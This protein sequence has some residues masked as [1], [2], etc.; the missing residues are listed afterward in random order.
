MS[1]CWYGGGVLVSEDLGGGGVFRTGIITS[2]VGVV[3]FE[4]GSGG[5]YGG[6]G[7]LRLVSVISEVLIK[8]ATIF[9]H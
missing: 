4:L 2:E 6:G 7:S 8:Y 3:T 9:M 1:A 5:V